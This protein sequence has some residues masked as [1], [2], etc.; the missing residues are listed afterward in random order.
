VAVSSSES[1][2]NSSVQSLL[3]CV[4]SPMHL[5]QS[6]V[7]SGSSRLHPSMNFGGSRIFITV[8][9]NIT[10]KITLQ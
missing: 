3:S 1:Y 10:T 9:K 6:A 2:A 8:F 5:G 7:L 4:Q